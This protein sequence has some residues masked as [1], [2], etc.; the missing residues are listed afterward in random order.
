MTS[1]G[2]N[3]CFTPVKNVLHESL[4]KILGDGFQLL[5]KEPDECGMSLGVLLGFKSG[6]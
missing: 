2:L 4:D 1:P 3:A 6:K 5:P